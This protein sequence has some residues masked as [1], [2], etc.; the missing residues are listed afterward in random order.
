LYFGSSPEILSENRIRKVISIAKE[1]RPGKVLDVGCGAGDIGVLA[2]AVL[3]TCD[4]YGV[5]IS[6]DAVAKA[7]SRGIISF[8]CNV[9][10]QP[11]PFQDSFF[12]LVIC[13]EIIEHL[14]DP[15]HLLDEVH[16]VL[17]PN[18][19]AV[20]TTPNLAAWYNRIALLIG[21]Q[22]FHTSPSPRFGCVGMPLA[23]PEAHG[24]HIRVFTF[25][26]LKELL[27]LHGFV[28]LE[29]YGAYRSLTDPKGSHHPYRSLRLPYMVVGRVLCRRPSLADHLIF[30][31]AK[32]SDLGSHRD[33]NS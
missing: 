18:G 12:D 8:L 3:I 25:R 28:V 22:P 26:A 17:K 20:F 29:Q 4:V 33:A 27:R 30:V 21:Y 10:E 16:R 24:Q 13:G 6:G 2:K 11:L 14:F 1:R 15:D 31:V 19:A 23:S 5:D 7:R 9:D 32:T